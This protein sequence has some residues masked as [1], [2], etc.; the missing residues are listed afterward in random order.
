MENTTDSCNESNENNLDNLSHEA[1]VTIISDFL[2]ENMIPFANMATSVNAIQHY[3]KE[4]LTQYSLEKYGGSCA[5]VAYYYKDI[6][7][8]FFK[9]NN[10]NAETIVTNVIGREKG[11]DGIL[12][13]HTL[14]INI[15][16][17]LYEYDHHLWQGGLV[18]ADG[19]SIPRALYKQ[20]EKG[21]KQ[22]LLVSSKITLDKNGKM[23][24]KVTDSS[25][26]EFYYNLDNSPDKATFV[27]NLNDTKILLNRLDR[28]IKANPKS[29]PDPFVLQGVVNEIRK[30]LIINFEDLV[31]NKDENPLQYLFLS[32]GDTG[33]INTKHKDFDRK[34]SEFLASFKDPIV[35]KEF[36]TLIHEL[37]RMTQEINKIMKYY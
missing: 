1:K 8:D 14:L 2:A 29:K 32:S 6:L 36:E 26:R 9:K 30:T 13:H 7:T 17:V 27:K 10:I 19:G 22:K 31:K 4:D 23:Q 12:G 25:G 35:E 21:Q 24:R 34:L 28:I 20:Q 3:L 5:Q 15:D 33:T 18:R 37:K 16:D 11:K